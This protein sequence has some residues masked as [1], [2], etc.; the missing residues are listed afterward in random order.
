M[1]IVDFHAHILPG[2]DDGSRNPDMTAQMLK[3]AAEQGI[4]TIVAT[5]HFYP[6]SM[7]FERFL[8]NRERAIQQT[9]PAAAACGIEILP[10]AEV[11]FFTGIGRADRL[12]S[13]CIA[14]TRLLLLEMPFRRWNMND[15]QEVEALLQRGY[16]ILLAHP[17][18]LMSFQTDRAVAAALL[19]MPV[20]AQINAESLTR[21]SARRTALRLMRSVGSVLGS[22]CHDLTARP[23]NLMAGRRMVERRLKGE[24]L[25][26][27]DRLAWQLL[28]NDPEI[29]Y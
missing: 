8:R 14:N 26:Q 6:D 2:I 5:P 25:Q 10:G 24:Y 20:F 15:L 22:D 29:Y 21:M 7:M 19:E 12:D 9:E 16:R 13:L 17:E 3:S 28:Q 4:K 18:R 1:K 27:M 23:Q 11:T